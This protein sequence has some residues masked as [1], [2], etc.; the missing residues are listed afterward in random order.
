M[1]G[2]A[3]SGVMVKGGEPG[4]LNE[5]MSL[6][7]AAFASRIAWRNVPAPLSPMLVTENS[8]ASAL[9]RRT[10]AL[11]TSK[12]VWIRLFNNL[13]GAMLGYADLA[14]EGV[15]AASSTAS[16]IAEIRAA[17]DR[18]AALTRQLLAFSRRQ[19]LQT[20][21]L[22]LTELFRGLERLLRR[23]ITEQVELATSFAADL[24]LV[25]ADPGQLEQV[26]INLAV[27][28]RDAMPQGG[29]LTLTASNVQLREPRHF[30][31][32][33]IGAG[34]F[35]SLV[36]EDTGEGMSDETQRHLFEPF[37]TTK[38]ESGTGLGLATCYGIVRQLGGAISARG[39]PGRGSAF[40]LY[41]PRCHGSVSPRVAAPAKRQ[42]GGDESILLV[43]DDAQLRE[44]TR[45]ALESAGYR[46]CVAAHAD[47][48]LRQLARPELMVALLVT[49]VLMPGMS[50]VQLAEIARR[51]RPELPVLYVSGYVEGNLVAL[52]FQGKNADFVAK[53]FSLRELCDRVRALLDRVG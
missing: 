36:V 2:S 39:E 41:L 50:G 16:D 29:R 1:F 19:V 7:G 3:V 17:A 8:A 20:K 42:A 43:E 53:P 15:P 21:V 10:A 30:G 47:E 13:I 31:D 28:A 18:A 38:A 14:L 48:A 5:M 12:A 11:R 49:D 45:R 24:W 23:V 25:E 22:D 9:N 44:S 6:P 27:N 52:D 34:E 32:H 40:T 46:V 26:V 37:F 33:E 35:V 4:R 51:T